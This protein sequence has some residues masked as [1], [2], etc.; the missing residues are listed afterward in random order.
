MNQFNEQK[1]INTAVIF[2]MD[3][4]PIDR[5]PMQYKSWVVTAEKEGLSISIADVMKLSGH[6][7]RNVIDKL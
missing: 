2:D 1:Q 3:D 7:S 6:T 4:V 5:M